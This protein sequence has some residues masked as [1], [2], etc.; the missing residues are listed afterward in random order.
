VG[1][2]AA[3]AILILALPGYLAAGVASAVALED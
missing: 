1:L 3:A 2:V